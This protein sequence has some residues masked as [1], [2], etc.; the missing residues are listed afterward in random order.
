MLR[1]VIAP[2]VRVNVVMSDEEFRRVND[3][4]VVL[5][6]ID[7][8]LRRAASDKKRAKTAKGKD[9]ETGLIYMQTRSSFSSTSFF[10]FRFSFSF[11]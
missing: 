6:G 9:N 10:S 5:I 1:K 8:R 11:H 4:V 7:R 3:V 2:K